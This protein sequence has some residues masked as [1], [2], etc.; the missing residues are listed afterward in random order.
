MPPPK[1]R[2]QTLMLVGIALLVIVL[3][4]K[5]HVINTLQPL[6][7]EV[8][9]IENGQGLTFCESSAGT[10]LAPQ[11]LQEKLSDFCANYWYKTGYH[12]FFMHHYAS[13]SSPP[14]E[15]HSALPQSLIHQYGIAG[16][17]QSLILI[18]LGRTLSP[19]AFAS[20]SLLS[21]VPVTVAVSGTLAAYK[22][23]RPA[24]CIFLYLAI[25][26][27]AS[28]DVFQFILSPGFTPLRH[29]PACLLLTLLIDVP[30]VHSEHKFAQS[31]FGGL[32]KFASS[33]QIKIFLLTILLA[34]INSV[35]SNLMILVGLLFSLFLL[36]VVK[37]AFQGLILNTRYPRPAT[38]PILTIT[39]ALAVITSLQLALILLQDPSSLASS[40]GQ[41]NPSRKAWLVFVLLFSFSFLYF[42][43][44]S[45]DMRG[46]RVQAFVTQLFSPLLIITSLLALYTFNFWGSANHLASGLLL[47]SVPL[48][49]VLANT[50]SA[51]H[52]VPPRN[53]SLVLLMKRA[54]AHTS[55]HPYSYLL[56]SP[57]PRNHNN[58]NSHFCSRL[59]I[60]LRLLV[61]FILPLISAWAIVAWYLQHPKASF[62]ADLYNLSALPNHFRSSA[63]RRCKTTPII[64]GAI[65]IDSCDG[66]RKADLEDLLQSLRIRMPLAAKTQQQ[67]I[68]VLADSG[69]LIG[70]EYLPDSIVGYNLSRNA[71]QL[72]SEIADIMDRHLQQIEA[73]TQ[74]SPGTEIKSCAKSEAPLLRQSLF[75]SR[76]QTLP[77]PSLRGK[78]LNTYPIV[79]F[80]SPK[81]A[82]EANAS[83]LSNM[84]VQWQQDG[85]SISSSSLREIASKLYTYFYRESLRLAFEAD[86]HYRQVP[87]D[88]ASFIAFA[89]TK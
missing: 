79:V 1:I 59:S 58:S 88:S 57:P 17:L 50:I 86:S 15:A 66:E 39:A 84:F 16:R 3:L 35:S 41:G 47:V 69:L 27:V 25:L 53:L 37:P 36:Y 42:G 20:I 77:L 67:N 11:T 9:E 70:P 12:G 44:S 55:Y 45:W 72:K 76:H 4:F 63:P 83:L 46:K 51:I 56:L 74:K 38:F 49:V 26:Y 32:K 2:L 8:A 52:T 28:L 24:A 81:L 43:R 78:V 87:A 65:A 34:L 7:F 71:Y 40:V 10:A 62:Q 85:R 18:A 80:L 33:Q 23:N 68:P 5:L 61:N 75:N 31:K 60:T 19:T 29:L 48:A 14:I 54:F 30:S 13:Y 6:I 82:E 21:L 64:F 89:R 22:R 73:C